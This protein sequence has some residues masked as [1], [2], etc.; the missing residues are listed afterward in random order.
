[1]TRPDL[2]LWSLRASGRVRHDDDAR[3]DFEID[4]A[5]V[6][7]S[8]AFRRLQG[9]T[10]ILSLGDDDFY[11]SR[12]THSMEVAQIAEGI[13]QQLRSQA[14]SEP[15]AGL[16]PPA[17]LIQAIGLAHDIGHPPFGHGGELALNYCIR[18]AGGFEGNAQT[19]RLL[20]QLENFSDV[21]GADL[22][23]RA[24]LGLLKYPALRATVAN[25]DIVP[26]LVTAPTMIAVLDS[27]S[28]KPAKSCY[29]ED[30]AALDWVLQ[31]LS[32]SDRDAF[33]AVTPKPGKHGATQHKSFDCTIMDA[34]DDIAYGVHDLEDAIALGFIDR[35]D[36]SA[37]VDAP[38]CDH[39]ETSLRHRPLVIGGRADRAELIDRLF[40]A[41]SARKA[42]IGRLVHYFIRSIRVT[43]EPVFAEP[44]LRWR[45]VLEPGAKTLLQALQDLIVLKV[46]DSP[47]VQHLEFKGQRMVMAVFEAI[48]SD[49][50]RL[51]PP[52]LARSFAEAGAPMRLLC[53]H[54]AGFTDG[55]LLRTY[56]RLFSPR[57]GSVFD[58]I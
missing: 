29:D 28:C 43:E 21:N 37:A 31:P 32:S 26:R 16:I 22:T 25:L 48:A 11:R 14:L 12:L 38:L 34:A 13:A 27:T 1:M 45:A 10:Q 33:V 5:R 50:M 3:T 6:I 23:R 7:H 44:L 54:I 15:I 52:A 9:K 19:L 56:E 35:E 49:P 20:S 55:T 36:F 41:P 4:Y 47:R 8:G 39:L 18:D 53:D 42:A 58:R 24:L 51:L 46:I 17:P 57:M 40:G 30:A 2:Q